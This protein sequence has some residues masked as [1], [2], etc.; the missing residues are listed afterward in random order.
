M[1]R[2]WFQN[3]LVNKTRMKFCY[4]GTFIFLIIPSLLLGQA[5]WK[6]ENIHAA[7]GVGLGGDP[8]FSWTDLRSQSG[9]AAF[10]DYSTS[11]LQPYRGFLDIRLSGLAQASVTAGFYPYSK[12]RGDYNGRKEWK[13]GIFYGYQALPGPKYSN[14]RPLINYRDTTNYLYLNFNERRQ[15]L[16]ITNS[17][18]F[19][20]NPER[21]LNLFGGAG[22]D[23]GLSIAGRINA[24][25]SKN[26]TVRTDSGTYVTIFNSEKY[27]HYKTYSSFLGGLQLFDGLG[28]RF[29][30]HYYF[31]YSGGFYMQYIDYFHASD[32]ANLFLFEKIELSIPLE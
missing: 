6:L 26:I 5:K 32:R 28:I 17:I 11:G 7:A 15:Y 25:N 31:S 1:Q 2:F 4:L 16:G 22:L 8:G 24:Y 20:T 10:P 3:C 21:R 29:L 13:M 12:K 19:R 30:H 27:T 23:F 18:A 14:A 9:S